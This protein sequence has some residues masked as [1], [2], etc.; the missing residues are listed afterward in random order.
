MTFGVSLK[1]DVVLPSWTKNALPLQDQMMKTEIKNKEELL[2]AA[3]VAVGGQTPEAAQFW[4]ELKERMDIRAE[5][6]KDM[7]KPREIRH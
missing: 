1:T 6:E 5:A 7:V 4:D 3:R 2:T